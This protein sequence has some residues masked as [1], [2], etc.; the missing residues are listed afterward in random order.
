LAS[1]PS[2]SVLVCRSRRMKRVLRGW[3]MPPEA[4]TKTRQS[5]PKPRPVRPALPVLWIRPTC[6]ELPVLWA[7]RTRLK[8]LVLAVR[9]TRLV[10]LVLAARR[11]RPA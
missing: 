7:C 11:P 9:R 4:S 1:R 2:R 3:K 6:L 10:V 5:A 8:L